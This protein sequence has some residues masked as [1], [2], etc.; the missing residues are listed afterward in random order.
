MLILHL[1]TFFAVEH[2]TKSQ[3][4]AVDSIV[5]QHLFIRWTIYLVLIF[6]VV[7]FGA[8]GNGYDLSGFL[9]GGF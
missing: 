7:L 1:V 3:D 5:S 8:Y 4:G 9:Y 2:K 6:D